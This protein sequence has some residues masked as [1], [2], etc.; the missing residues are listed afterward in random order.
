M[1]EK[2]VILKMIL[3]FEIAFKFILLQILNKNKK[4][5]IDL[6][7]VVWNGNEQND[8]LTYKCFIEYIK[9]NELIFV[10]ET[11]VHFINLAIKNY[12]LNITTD[13]F[14]INL[15]YFLSNLS[16]DMY[17]TYTKSSNTVTFNVIHF[18][19]YFYP[20]MIFND[21]DAS[22]KFNQF[23]TKN[24][25]QLRNGFIK[26][27]PEYNAK[28][29][30]FDQN[31]VNTLLNINLENKCV[32]FHTKPITLKYVF[33]LKNIQKNSDIIRDMQEYKKI[34]LWIL[35]YNYENIQN[36]YDM[37]IKIKNRDYYSYIRSN[38]YFIH[39]NDSYSP[40]KLSRRFLSLVI[41]SVI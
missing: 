30:I 6:N 22:N 33:F 17:C 25:L 1:W 19:H 34:I 10:L 26:F 24:N 28:E 21:R 11:N 9:T 35:E 31:G 37:G 38:L 32:L 5:Y 36:N 12:S 15:T 13:D 23:L 27:S 3:N 20:G 4:R 18:N 39:K 8:D 2:V 16:E 40:L 41:A 29:K 14:I 7:I